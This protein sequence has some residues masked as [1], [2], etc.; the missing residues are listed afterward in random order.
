MEDRKRRRQAGFT[1]VELMVVIVII[2][3]LAGMGA[4]EFEQ[5]VFSTDKDPVICPKCGA[6]KPER[7]LSVFSSNAATSDKG[8]ASSGACSSPSGGFS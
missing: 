2:G 1:L 3:I 4:D 7:L 5:I 8:H 6:K